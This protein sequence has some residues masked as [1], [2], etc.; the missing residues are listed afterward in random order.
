M[1]KNLDKASW[2]GVLTSQSRQLDHV[3]SVLQHREHFVQHCLHCS[4]A[5]RVSMLKLTSQTA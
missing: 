2:I 3:L 5:H 1:I 4:D